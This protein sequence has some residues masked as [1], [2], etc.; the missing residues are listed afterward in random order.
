VAKSRKAAR[1]RGEGISS[2]GL[3]S[4]RPAHRPLPRTHRSPSRHGRTQDVPIRALR[5]KAAHLAGVRAPA[6]TGRRQAPAPTGAP[7]PCSSPA[8]TPP[9]GCR[10]PSARPKCRMCWTRH[11]R[12]PRT[13]RAGR[14]WPRAAGRLWKKGRGR[15]CTKISGNACR[16]SVRPGAVAPRGGRARVASASK[17]RSECLGHPMWGG[18]GGRVPSMVGCGVCGAD[19]P[20]SQAGGRFFF[21]VALSQRNESRRAVQPLGSPGRGAGAAESGPCVWAGPGRGPAGRAGGGLD[22]K[23]NKKMKKLYRR[24]RAESR[25]S[26]ESETRALSSQSSRARAA[27]SKKKRKTKEHAA[28][29]F[30][31]SPAGR[32]AHPAL[33]RAGHLP[34]PGH[35]A[36]PGAV[37]LKEAHEK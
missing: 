6:R 13:G 8:G 1:E 35:R 18:R 15:G 9:S 10:C 21:P 19:G 34:R 26:P 33:G 17:S 3:F 36:R 30:H 24:V 31:A 12:T 20:Q 29:P 37:G 16:N 23:G 28:T 14:W 32:P 22:V 25:A 27:S 2:G 5:E 4:F 7:R 11:R